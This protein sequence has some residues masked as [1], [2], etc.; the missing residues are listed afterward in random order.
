M[1][2]LLLCLCS[3]IFVLSYQ[4]FVLMSICR[5][6]IF[7]TANCFPDLLECHLAFINLQCFGRMPWLIYTVQNSSDLRQYVN[8]GNDA[9]EHLN[10]LLYW[11]D[12]LPLLLCLSQHALRALDILS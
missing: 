11:N 6:T 10:I 1:Y 9:V 5:F 3:V 4:L 7:G 2:Y 8:V 12:K